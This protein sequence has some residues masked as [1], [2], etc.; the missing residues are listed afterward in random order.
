MVT[1]HRHRKIAINI[2]K[3]PEN[4]PQTLLF[5]FLIR[6]NFTISRFPI[7][8]N[9]TCV[10]PTTIG[11]NVLC[12]PIATTAIPALIESAD[13]ANPKITASNKSI[14]FDSSKS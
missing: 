12:I 11:T 1:T 10:K 14:F 9:P 2:N 13:R 4:T 6:E 8:K 3:A 5:N 7:V